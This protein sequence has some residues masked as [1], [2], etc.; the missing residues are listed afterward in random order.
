MWLN[1]WGFAS[2]S[3]VKWLTGSD[4]KKKHLSVKYMIYVHHLSSDYA[5]S[6]WVTVQQLP[7]ALVACFYK[8]KQI[9]HK[10]SLHLKRPTSAGAS[11]QQNSSTACQQNGGVL[12]RKSFFTVSVGKA[13][14]H[15]WYGANTKPLLPKPTMKQPSQEA[16]CCATKKK[17]Q[18]FNISLSIIWRHQEPAAGEKRLISSVTSEKK[19]KKA[20]EIMALKQ[21]FRLPR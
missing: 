7:K 19:K 10:A 11:S 6:V 17:I 14:R 13:F 3:D 12:S 16:H 1:W 15:V 5:L 8:S 9:A 4:N 21:D 18:Y 2:A 20:N